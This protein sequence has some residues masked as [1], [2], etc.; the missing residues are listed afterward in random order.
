MSCPNVLLM[1]NDMKDIIEKNENEWIVAWK[2]STEDWVIN[3]KYIAVLDWGSKFYLE[4]KEG[5]GKLNYK[6][7]RPHERL[8]FSFVDFVGFDTD[9]TDAIFIVFKTEERHIA[10]PLDHCTFYKTDQPPI[11]KKIKNIVEQNQI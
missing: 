1:E 2:P 11:I 3:R 4:K 5:E 9:D 6:Y 8:V 10:L 7:T